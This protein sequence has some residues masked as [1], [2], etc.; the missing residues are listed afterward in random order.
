M[1]LPQSTQVPRPGPL[2][3]VI[4][5]HDEDGHHEPYD[6]FQLENPECGL[7]HVTRVRRR[8]SLLW[9]Y[10]RFTGSSNE[11][12]QQNDTWYGEWV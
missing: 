3:R 12:G 7:G 8:G 6:V 1:T 9:R 11:F 5:I 2:E 4:V 10:V